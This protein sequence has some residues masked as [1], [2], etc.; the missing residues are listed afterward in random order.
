MSETADT[1]AYRHLPLMRFENQ[2][3]VNLALRK[4]VYHFRGA[5]AT[6][7]ACPVRLDRR[8]DEGRAGRD[9]RSPRLS[10]MPA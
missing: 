6:P 5:I 4:H 2:A 9:P 8:H 10:I 7:G 3:G 1:T